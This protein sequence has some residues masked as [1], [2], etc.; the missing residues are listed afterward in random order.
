MKNHIFVLAVLASGS[1]LAQSTG[2]LSFQSVLQLALEKGSDVANQQTT[3]NT[4]RTDLQAKTEDPSTLIVPLTQA[5]QSVQLE[6]LKLDFVKL[7]LA[8]N[9]L[10]SYLSVL[11]AQENLNVLKAQVELDQMNL[12]INKA[13]LSSKNATQLDVS[14]AQN[15]LNSSQQDL[16]NAQSNF[17]VLKEKLNAFTG[18]AL[19]ANFTVSQPNLKLVSHKLE[20]LLDQSES[21]LPTLL[22]SAQS[23]ALAQM[24]VQ[25]ADNDYTPKSTLDSARASLQTAQRNQQGQRNS[26]QSSIKDAYQSVQNTLER[27]KFSEE[28]LKNALQTLSQ[29]QTRFK[30][31]LISKYQL[32][33]SE[34][35]VL[36][37]EQSLLQARDSYLKAVAGLAV[38]SGMDT[39]NA[40]GGIE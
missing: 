37:S 17:P 7:Q 6:S 4:A 20:D 12:D 19:P 23:V 26:A 36:K 28:D 39:L 31:G 10:S 35:S 13:K 1:T 27:S 30:N 21:N 16:K 40:L 14:K 24:N 3:L 2:A 29:D 25:F 8:Q 38:A 11:E 9:V 32:K 5:Q 15:T 22:Q 33:Q 34:V 18:G